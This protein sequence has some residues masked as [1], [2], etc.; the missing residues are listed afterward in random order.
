LAGGYYAARL[1]VLEK[2]KSIRKQAAVFAIREITPDYWAP[3]GV[4][5]VREAA[6]NTLSTEP[7]SFENLEE[8]LMDMNTRI[9]TPFHQWRDKSELLPYVKEQTTL[10]RFLP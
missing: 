2:L 7:D 9:N 5:V 10:S 1:P 8:A 4:W 6:R 3:L